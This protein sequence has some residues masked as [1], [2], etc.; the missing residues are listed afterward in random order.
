[1]WPSNKR[2]NILRWSDLQAC[3]WAFVSAIISLQKR[4][5]RERANAVVDIVSSYET[6]MT[7]S[8][9]EYVC[10]TGALRAGVALKGKVVILGR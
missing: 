7:V 3:E 8:E 10:G 6:V 1:V 2:S 9:T 4:A 5:R